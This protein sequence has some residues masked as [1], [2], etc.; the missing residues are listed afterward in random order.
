[1]GRA[2]KIRQ[3]FNYNCGEVWDPKVIKNTLD[4]AVKKV[5]T[6]TLN[7]E[8]DYRLINRCLGIMI[9]NAIMVAAIGYIWHY[10]YQNQELTQILIGCIGTYFFMMVVNP[11]YT[12]AYKYRAKD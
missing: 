2:E 10:F 7:F 5:L 4:D 9:M 11:H 3:I 6:K 1:M 8:E 12:V